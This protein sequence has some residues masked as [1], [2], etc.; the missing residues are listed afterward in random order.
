MFVSSRP[1]MYKTN[2]LYRRH[3]SM[4]ISYGALSEL[5]VYSQ[6]IPLSEREGYT[7]FCYV[8]LISQ[9]GCRKN[10]SHVCIYSN[11]W[12]LIGF[13]SLRKFQKVAWQS[14][15]TV[16]S[17]AATALMESKILELF[18]EV[19]A[20]SRCTKCPLAIAKE[21]FK[22]SR[23]FIRNLPDNSQFR[24]I[25]TDSLRCS[26]KPARNSINWL[27]SSMRRTSVQLEKIYYSH[28][29]NLLR[30]RISDCWSVAQTTKYSNGVL[31]AT[32]LEHATGKYR[33]RY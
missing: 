24:T 8:L 33:T 28:A 16:S 5:E 21:G 20:N 9:S 10:L 25:K 2:S 12:Y 15:D 11:S 3:R 19:C 27:L 17:T 30:N 32:D 1:W 18:W 26:S 7:A 22:M 6:I 13:R 14:Q 4:D 31:W 23:A 29:I